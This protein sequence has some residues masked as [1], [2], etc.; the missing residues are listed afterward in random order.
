[1]ATA[2]RGATSGYFTENAI[3]T[4]GGPVPVCNERMQYNTLGKSGLLVS[5]LAFGAMTFGTG[6]GALGSIFKVDQK[7]ADQLV[8]K[9]LDAGINFFN[10]ADA[11]AGGESERML[12]KALG[13]RRKDAVITTKVGFRTG[14]ALVQQGLSRH[15]ILN[16]IDESLSR[17][18]TD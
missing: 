9:A 3:V 14:D 18:G 7:L 8:G 4:G 10:T 1:A 13:A 16:A 11:Y 15:H 17:L 2:A 12:G 5:R 6:E